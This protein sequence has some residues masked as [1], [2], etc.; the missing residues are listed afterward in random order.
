MFLFG[1]LGVTDS[2][3]HCT[4]A[5][6]RANHILIFQLTESKCFCLVKLY[7]WRFC[8]ALLWY[9][10]A[11]ANIIVHRRSTISTASLIYSYSAVIRIEIVT[12]KWFIGSNACVCIK[13]DCA[14]SFMCL[15]AQH[16]Y[17]CLLCSARGHDTNAA[18]YFFSC[19]APNG[20]CRSINLSWFCVR[21]Q[22][23]C[24]LGIYIHCLIGM[25][26]ERQWRIS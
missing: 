12:L 10:R 18:V 1:L 2:A 11:I 9:F 24:Q 17:P 19:S 15:L 14:N 23:D 6:N 25:I 26:Y 22:F 8:I 21:H 16:E 3:F 20:D 7:C 13:G 4:R 5:T